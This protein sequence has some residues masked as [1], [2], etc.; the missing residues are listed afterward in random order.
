MQS[1]PYSAMSASRKVV[2]WKAWYADGSVVE[3]TTGSLSDANL[4]PLTGLIEWSLKY[5]QQFAPGKN[6]GRGIGN[7]WYGFQWNVDSLEVLSF[8][9]VDPPDNGMTWIEG[10]LVSDEQYATIQQAAESY[11]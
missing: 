7:D 11:P 5:D 8:D 10:E 6:Y 3:S 1:M 9:G 4:L 2:G